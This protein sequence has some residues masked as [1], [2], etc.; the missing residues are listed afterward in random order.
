VFRT[1]KSLNCSF[2]FRIAYF[3]SS[4]PREF[5]KN[6]ENLENNIVVLP[7]RGQGGSENLV[8][9]H[10]DNSVA[11]LV[12]VAALYS[13]EQ[14]DGNPFLLA[15]HESGHDLSDAILIETPWLHIV[16]IFFVVLARLLFAGL[17]GDG[18]PPPIPIIDTE[19]L[20]GSMR[21][22]CRS[23]GLCLTSDEAGAIWLAAV[24]RLRVSAVAVHIIVENQLLAGFDVS[25]GKN[26]HAQLVTY[27]PFVHV[28]IR[29]ARM[30]AKATEIAFLR[31]IN[32][33]V[34]RKG[35]KI[36]M[37][38][39]F[40]VLLERTP[41]E[42]WLVDDFAN[43]LEN[44]IIGVQVGICAQAVALPLCLDDR[45]IGVLFS[46]ESLILTPD[47]TIAVAHTFHFSCTIDTIGIFSARMILAIDWD[48][49]QHL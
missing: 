33:F 14:F 42:G 29:I 35:H 10:L 37:L 36:K 17:L 43:V 3:I 27:H 8:A 48:T 26:A 2:N 19:R 45:D 44:E 15:L 11:D 1:D 24:A 34:L 47:T 46:L 7:P 49:R 32:E 22:L 40:F 6:V 39:A 23:L 25:L 12:V 31:G 41:P 30:V 28:A 4:K 9:V 38:D 13:T 21:E 18:V 16:D 20:D 5:V